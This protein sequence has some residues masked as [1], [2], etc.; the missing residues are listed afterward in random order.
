MRW[1]DK[2]KK[3]LLSTKGRLQLCFFPILMTGMEK[4]EEISIEKKTCAA[5]TN[6]GMRQADESGGERRRWKMAECDPSMAGR[7]DENQRDD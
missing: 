1:V 3:R 7:R 5:L 4:K 2:K 6:K